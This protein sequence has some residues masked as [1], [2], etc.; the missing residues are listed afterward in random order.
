M[1]MKCLSYKPGKLRGSLYLLRTVVVGTLM[2]CAIASAQAPSA[3]GKP[4]AKTSLQLAHKALTE[5]TLPAP[6]QPLILG[7]EV[8]GTREI[9][10]PMKIVAV[11]DGRLLPVPLTNSYRNAA[12]RPVYEFEL[13][14]PLAE[15]SYQ[16]IVPLSGGG[17]ASSDRFTVR[18]PCV[19]SLN[20]STLGNSKNSELERLAISARVL[21]QE[22]DAYTAA[23][24]ATEA[25]QKEIAT[26]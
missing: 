3:S 11:R 17:V 19:P 6:G 12:E 21:E 8:L 10:L 23:L 26:Q 24:N 2:I 15:L 4:A 5:K 22:I 13:A 7:V 14:S 1:D 25:L 18:R 20:A 9:S 16:F